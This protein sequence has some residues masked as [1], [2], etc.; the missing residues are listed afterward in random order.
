ME[1]HRHMAFTNIIHSFPIVLG[2]HRC[3]I[4]ELFFAKEELTFSLI[5]IR[6]L[7]VKDDPTSDLV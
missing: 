4:T 7:Q 1:K 5:K 2:G 6:I 3:R